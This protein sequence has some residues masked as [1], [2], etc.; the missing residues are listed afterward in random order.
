MHRL[1]WVAALG[2]VFAA[3]YL[4]GG[5]SA[6]G[7][8]SKDEVVRLRASERRLQHRVEALEATL[9][10]EDQVGAGQRADAR[11]QA[12]VR[13]G[14]RWPD[15]SAAGDR[16]PTYGAVDLDGRPGPRSGARSSASDRNRRA[17]DP[18]VTAS[19]S[20]ALEHFYAYLDEMNAP[21]AQARWQKMQQ[22]ADELR[23]MGPVGAEVLVEMLEGGTTG[24]ERRVA[25]Q[26]LGELQVQQALPLLRNIVER[27]SDT[28]LRRAAAA[29]LRRLQTPET[30]PVLESLLADPGEDRSIRMSAASGLAQMDRS[31]GVAGLMQIFESASGDAD[32]RA[33]A[34][35]ALISLN[36]ERALPFMRQLVTS[37][38]ETTYR[39][40][41]I[42]YLSGQ[43]DAQALPSLQ[44]V[45][46]SATE[47]SSI[48]DAAAQAH[49]AISGR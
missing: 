38:A 17:A 26:L 7:G 4:A 35:R 2:P 37:N 39:L 24:D 22:L 25:A 14:S 49:S 31:Q 34:F 16:A 5:W 27:D 48:R 19:T 3:G 9:R 12:P 28:A 15:R 46:R 20:A 44:Q 45:M 1:L 41:A 10:D 18:A 36:D 43:G 33:L 6:L 13:G 29:G 40:R 8:A 30:V 47:P 11:R 21:G 23:R 32:G 42:R